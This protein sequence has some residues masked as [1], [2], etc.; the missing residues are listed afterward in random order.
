MG[1]WIAAAEEVHEKDIGEVCQVQ[2]LQQAPPQGDGHDLLLKYNNLDQFKRLAIQ[3]SPMMSDLMVR[4]P[5]HMH[6]Q[7]AASRVCCHD[8]MSTGTHWGLHRR[9]WNAH[10]HYN[11]LL[12]L[13]CLLILLAYC[14]YCL[15]SAL[16]LF[17]L[18]R[19]DQQA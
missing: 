10:M 17:M 11:L 6:V 2:Q 15:H 9:Q 5:P 14:P 4:G 1:S 8:K 19:Q 12:L 3:L 13:L 18:V 16:H 7:C